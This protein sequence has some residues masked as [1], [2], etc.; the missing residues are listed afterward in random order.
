MSIPNNYIAV[1]ILV[2]GILLTIWCFVKGEGYAKQIKWVLMFYFL[3]AFVMSDKFDTLKGLKVLGDLI[4]VDKYVS[5]L[6]EVTA[7]G[8][9]KLNE[10]HELKLDAFRAMSSAKLEKTEKLANET[11][12]L[13][14]LSVESAVY[15]QATK[16]NEEIIR[17]RLKTLAP[18]LFDNVSEGDQ[19]LQ[20]MLQKLE[21]KRGGEL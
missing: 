5:Q 17:R 20:S 4:N 1:A 21:K 8:V 9:Q 18:Y 14:R 10:T 15:D 16:I 12:A 11:K 6:K 7:E 2:L 19:W 13:M 3:A